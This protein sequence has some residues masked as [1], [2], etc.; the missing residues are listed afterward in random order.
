MLVKLRRKEHRMHKED[1][2]K[3][4]VRR[5]CFEYASRSERKAER[6]SVTGNASCGRR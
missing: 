2:A 5:A 4:V 6:K 3:K 1:Q